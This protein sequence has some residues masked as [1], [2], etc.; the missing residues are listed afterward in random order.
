VHRVAPESTPLVHV[1]YSRRAEVVL[2]GDDITLRPPFSF[3][4]GEFTLTAARDDDK[5][6][7]SRVSVRRGVQRRQCPLG[8]Y[9]VVKT[10][11]EM[12]GDYPQ[13]V[14]F[15]RQ[16]N[17]CHCLSC[18]LAVDAL[19]QATSVYY[20]AQHGADDPD[21]QKGD[22]EEIRNARSE[23]LATPT[24]FDRS[25]GRRPSVIRRADTGQGKGGESE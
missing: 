8:L 15:L 20:L 17:V 21:F 11:G 5:C 18:A 19:P 4:A 25:G 14:E 16:A 6:T 23:F 3:L 13:V 1:S 9:D 2:F 7:V 12:G 10:L 22:D 24:L